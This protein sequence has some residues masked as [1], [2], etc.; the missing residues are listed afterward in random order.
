MLSSTSFL[1]SASGL[2]ARYFLN[3]V[4]AS[5]FLPTSWSISPRSCHASAFSG[6]AVTAL[7]YHSTAFG[8]CFFS[9]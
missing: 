3:A 7:R 6:S 1:F 9:R 5:F 4:I 8:Y 2:S